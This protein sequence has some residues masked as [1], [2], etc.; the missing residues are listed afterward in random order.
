VV[1]VTWYCRHFC[2]N[3]EDFGLITP[4]LANGEE[5]D[6]VW[7]ALDRLVESCPLVCTSL[8]RSK[9]YHPYGRRPL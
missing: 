6:R 5:S 8:A 7:R 3:L 9:L 4:T 2:G 1:N